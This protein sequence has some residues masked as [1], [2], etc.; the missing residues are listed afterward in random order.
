MQDHAARQQQREHGRA[1]EVAQAAQALSEAVRC[2][3]A[4][5]VDRAIARLQAV[6]RRETPPP[7]RRARR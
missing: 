7:P 2:G 1:G 5:G 4:A 6:H 3:D